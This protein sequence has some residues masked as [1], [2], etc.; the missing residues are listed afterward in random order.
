MSSKK[1]ISS[2][3]FKRMGELKDV[4]M[5]NY[6]VGFEKVLESVRRLNK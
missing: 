6:L 2:S 3:G 4:L 1:V 5:E